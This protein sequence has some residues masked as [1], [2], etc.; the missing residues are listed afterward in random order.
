VSARVRREHRPAK[1][2]V[3]GAPGPNQQRLAELACAAVVH[4]AEV[5]LDAA[6]V[7]GHLPDRLPEPAEHRGQRFRAHDGGDRRCDQ[8]MTGNVGDR[9]R[10]RR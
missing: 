3:P 1:L 6:L 2:V 5:G 9:A 4:G 7:R 10:P 8:R